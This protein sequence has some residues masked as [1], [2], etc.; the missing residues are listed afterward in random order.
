MSSD[1]SDEDLIA[2]PNLT[3]RHPAMAID[4]SDSKI[5]YVVAAIEEKGRLPFWLA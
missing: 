2:E 4:P 3:E 5:F 1:H